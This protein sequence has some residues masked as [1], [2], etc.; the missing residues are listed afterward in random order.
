MGNADTADLYGELPGRLILGA[1]YRIAGLRRDKDDYAVF[2]LE[3]QRFGPS[4]SSGAFDRK[5][6]SV[7][8]GG[9]EYSYMLG[10]ARLPIRIGVQNLASGGDN[11]R[12]RSSIEYGFGYRSKDR[13]YGVDF[14]W[15]RV[16][17]G[18]TDFTVTGEYRFQ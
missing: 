10:L 13:L 11:F 12:G 17:N 5:P 3:W 1:G 8:G 14:N 7:L 18:G 6:Q 2:G 16:T 9:L 15:A 4:R